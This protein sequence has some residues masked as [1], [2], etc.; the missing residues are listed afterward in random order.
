ANLHDYAAGNAFSCRCRIG[1]TNRRRPSTEPKRNH[2][3]S[4]DALA[5]FTE[6]LYLAFLE[7]DPEI[8]NKRTEEANGRHLQEQ[9]RSLARGDYA[10]VVKR[11]TE[12]VD[13][14]IIGP[15]GMPFVG[16]WQGR[17]GVA[18]A[19]KQNFAQVDDQHP[20]ILSVI[21]QGDTVVV[22][23]RERGRF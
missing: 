1:Y 8:P 7:G 22:F 10:S 14:E 6:R 19:L 2:R 9:Y 16:H 3:M 5:E 11:M 15:A 23:A 4:P 12:D 13:L 18:E 17:D 20:E 21:A